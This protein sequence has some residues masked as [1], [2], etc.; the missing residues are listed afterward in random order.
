[1]ALTIK[2]SVRLRRK[3]SADLS[4]GK[5]RVRNKYFEPAFYTSTGRLT[6]AHAIFDEH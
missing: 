6:H 5:G 3:H 1:M 4:T 2:T